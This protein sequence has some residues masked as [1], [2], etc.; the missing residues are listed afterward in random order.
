MP[1]VLHFIVPRAKEPSNKGMKLTSVEHIERSQL[2]PGVRRTSLS[3]AGSAR[4][5]LASLLLAVVV[6]CGGGSQSKGRSA[7][8]TPTGERPKSVGDGWTPNRPPSL[9]IG[10]LPESADVYAAVV[11]EF[12]RLGWKTVCI[13]AVLDP[14]TRVAVDPPKDAA[15]GL[16]R[17]AH[18]FRPGSSC[19]QDGEE[20]IEMPTGAKDAVAVTLVGAD[21]DGEDYLVRVY[22]CCWTGW[23]TFRFAR[24]RHGWW[25]K[26]TEGWLQT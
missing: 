21:I 23:G 26:Q 4:R 14:A 8:A 16:K 24:G 3:G 18:A 11:H 9:T 6:A 5:G 7:A 10:Q 15:S 25:L 1:A 13:S 17:D 2:I 20:V 19:R 12:V 22:W